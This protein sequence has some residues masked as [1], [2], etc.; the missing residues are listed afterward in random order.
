MYTM[1]GSRMIT[2][3]M[4]MK[5]CT[6]V[7]LH[8]H[9]LTVTN[10]LEPLS[11]ANSTRSMPGGTSPAGVTGGR[12]VSLLLSARG[13]GTCAEPTA[14]VGYDLQLILEGLPPSGMLCNVL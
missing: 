11:H 6:L 3:M 10:S 1:P 4:R 2:R 9:S 7:V 12:V 8:Q 13:S 5:V 14:E